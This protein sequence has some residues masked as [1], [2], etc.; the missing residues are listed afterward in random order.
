MLKHPPP[1]RMTAR[2]GFDMFSD[3]WTCHTQLERGRLE[4]GILLRCEICGDLGID[5]VNG[6]LSYHR[7]LS[8]KLWDAQ[9]PA[10]QP[11]DGAQGL[12]DM[13]T[14]WKCHPTRDLGV[15]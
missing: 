12:F 7:V 5:S 15:D 13:F 3:C 9:T 10:S 14:N 6:S 11:H 4:T 2:K 8:G 1:S